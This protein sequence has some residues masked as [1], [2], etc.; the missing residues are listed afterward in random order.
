M[1]L[2]GDSERSCSLLDIEDYNRRPK[3][4]ENFAGYTVFDSQW[5]DGRIYPLK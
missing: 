2:E 3:L 4:L 1:S 5:D